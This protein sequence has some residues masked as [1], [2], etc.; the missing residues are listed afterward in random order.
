MQLNSQIK[1][2]RTLMVTATVAT[3]SFAVP[4]YRPRAS[5]LGRLHRLY[6]Q[7]QSF[8]AP[9]A[10][11]SAFLNG[12]AG[13]R[14]SPPKLA[15]NENHA[16]AAIGSDG[17]R[18]FSFL[19]HQFFLARRDLPLPRM[20]H[21]PRQKDNDHR[22]R[23]RYGQRD[24]SV[25]PATRYGRPNQHQRAKDHGHHSS[26]AQNPMRG[27][28]RFE[29]E[30]RNRKNNQQKSRQIHGQHVHSEQRQYQRDSTDYA[31]SEKPRMREFRVQSQ[32]SDDEQNEK[33]I[34]LHDTREKLLARRHFF[35]DEDRICQRKLRARPI[36]A[37]DR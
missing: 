18:H 21:Q 9:Y 20:H 28:L 15:M 31:G 1:K 35:H 32:H 13:R 10:D 34:R 29:N 16:G 27:I 5:L 14:R 26:D 8:D 25:H 17:L 23:N 2:I 6:V 3:S 11:T 24:P 30:Q 12:R 22:E 37:S 19:A 4:P 33:H 36:E 7:N